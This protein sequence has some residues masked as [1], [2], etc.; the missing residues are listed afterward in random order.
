MAMIV[1]KRNLP[2]IGDTVESFKW[3]K[4]KLVVWINFNSG[5]MV[6]CHVSH[7]TAEHKEGLSINSSSEEKVDSPEGSFNAP[8]EQLK[9]A[10]QDLLCE[11]RIDPTCLKIMA[12]GYAPDYPGW[13]DGAKPKDW[14]N[15]FCKVQLSRVVAQKLINAGLTKYTV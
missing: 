5:K 1:N 4:D 9:T 14:E 6:I 7:R 12:H 10:V 13:P 11:L 8:Y 15:P 3:S 2:E